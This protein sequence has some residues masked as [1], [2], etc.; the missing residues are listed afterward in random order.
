MLLCTFQ[1]PAQAAGQSAL[2][3]SVSSV[4]LDVDSTATF[5]VHGVGATLTTAATV[6]S[7]VSRR[8]RVSSVS[9]PETGSVTVVIQG[10]SA[11]T[12]SIKIHVARGFTDLTI[13]V[14]VTSRTLRVTNLSSVLSNTNSTFSLS[15][16]SG[17]IAPIGDVVATSSKTSVLTVTRIASVVDNQIHVAVHGLVAG[18]ARVTVRTTGFKSL[19]FTVTVTNPGLIVSESN[20]VLLPGEVKYVDVTSAQAP[21]DSAAVTAMRQASTSPSFSVRKVTPIL[22]NSARFQVTTSAAGNSTITFSLTNYTNVRLSVTLPSLTVNSSTVSIWQT[23]TLSINVS[24]NDLAFQNAQLRAT[25]VEGKDS[26]AIVF[27]SKLITMVNGIGTFVISAPPNDGLTDGLSTQFAVAGLNSSI[28]PVV[29]TV[30]I[31]KPTLQFDV[32][33]VPLVVGSNTRVKVSSSDAPIASDAVVVVTSA[34]PIS[35]GVGVPRQDHSVVITGLTPS[36]GLV[37][38]NFEVAGYVPATL[39]V[40]VTASVEVPVQPA[41]KTA[42][43]IT[44]RAKVGSRLSVTNGAWT[45]SAFFTY[46]YSW[47]RCPAVAASSSGV[48]PDT[49]SAISS[50]NTNRYQIVSEDV[51][52]YIRGYVIAT[53]LAGS[54]SQ[55]TK[56]TAKVTK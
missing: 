8:V 15:P 40:S 34:K 33:N 20:M 37:A 48:I 46:T 31:R 28:T 43:T 49:C 55:L 2:E 52:M 12:A 18:T 51:G 17:V 19:T 26:S 50:A 47:Y 1:M 5:V 38:V 23:G 44:G 29:Q 27:I 11:G 4:S 22:A 42:P 7:T 3:A 9:L 21:L 14:T 45:G 6:T 16:S 13:P 56:S 53:N 39:Y 30:V 10:M 25:F 35:A 36:S 24:S 41:T 54:A 32:P